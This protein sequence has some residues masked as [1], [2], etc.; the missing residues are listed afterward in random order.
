MN[1]VAHHRHRPA[2][3]E[4]VTRMLLAAHLM[5]DGRAPGRDRLGRAGILTQLFVG[6]A[7]WV[8]RRRTRLQLERL[9]PSLLA[10]IGLT[11]ADRQRECLKWFWQP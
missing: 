8:Q 3:V 1:G 9:S 7:M 11:E 4:P 10:D 2:A 5:L 6:A